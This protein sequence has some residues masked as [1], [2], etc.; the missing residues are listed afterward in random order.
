MKK[1]RT[2]NDE[3]ERPERL[4]ETCIYYIKNRTCVAYLDRIPEKYWKQ[5]VG[6]KPL[7]DSPKDNPD[8]DN[9]FYKEKYIGKLE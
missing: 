5:K 2:F 9:I 8:Y 7:H 3:I 4:C 1:I 6:E